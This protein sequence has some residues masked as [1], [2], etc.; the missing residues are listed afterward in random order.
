MSLPKVN[1]IVTQPTGALFG[2][3]EKAHPLDAVRYPIL[4]ILSTPR[5]S[6]NMMLSSRQLPRCSSLLSRSFSSLPKRSKQEGRKPDEHAVNQ[7][8]DPNV[9][10]AA[11]QSGMKERE[12][13]HPDKSNAIA[14]RGGEENEKAKKQHPEAPRPVIGMNDERGGVRVPMSFSFLRISLLT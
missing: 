12:K 7:T 13:Q 8:N 3:V 9:Q 10:S 6:A 4:L 11:S 5:R 1:Y 2:S 14:Q